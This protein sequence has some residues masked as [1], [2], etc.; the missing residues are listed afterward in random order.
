MANKESVKPFKRHFEYHNHLLDDATKEMNEWT[1]ENKVVEIHLFQMFSE[2]FKTH[3]HDAAEALFIVGTRE[4][5][6]SLE[7]VSVT[8]VKPWLFSRVFAL[9][10]VS[11]FLLAMLFLVFRSNNAVPGMIFIGS[12]TVPFSLMMMFFEMNVFQNISVYQLLT[13]FLV[14]GILSLVATMI[15][16]SLIP[17]G[18]G[19]SLGSAVIIGF[20]EETAKMLVIA[21]FINRFHLNYIFN[22]LLV[23]AAIG[24]GFAVFETA[25]YTGQYGLVTLLMRSW[26]AI[27]THTIWSAIMG[28]AIILAKDRHQ[29]VTGSN[30]VAPKFLRFY[31]LAIG[32]HAAWDWNAPF[33]VLN[34][35]YLQQWLLI[36][37]GW[38]AIFVLINAGLREARTL[39]GQRILKKT[40]LG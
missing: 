40:Q 22:G 6:P 26:Q 3:D 7:A 1:G 2:V 37:V 33:A 29:P 12:L 23:G 27:G 15:L 21:S 24:A 30:M 31:I 28:A 9:L 4:T 17:S 10:G 18:N 16:Y 39:Q 36:A 8:P 25:G 14:G 32:L 19:V 11:F 35:L 20:I 34:I 38:L 5:T 13:V